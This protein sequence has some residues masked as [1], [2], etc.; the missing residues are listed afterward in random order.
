MSSRQFWF[1]VLLIVGTSIGAGFG[2]FARAR[3]WGPHSTSNTL[4]G[5]AREGR[6][7]INQPLPNVTLTDLEGRRNNLGDAKGKVIVFLVQGNKCPCSAAYVDRINAIHEEYGPKGVE[8]WAFNPNA[9]ETAEETRA[10]VDEKK[11][12]YSTAYDT[13][14]MV[15]GMLQAACTT[16]A[17]VADRDGVLRYHGRVDDNIY[18]P[19]KVTEH[20]LRVALD[21]VLAGEP[22][23]KPETS[24]YACTIS[25]SENL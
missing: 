15:A 13:N 5:P 20:D 21:A 9:N 14:G 11:V 10:F 23:P 4:L 1:V 8:I 17:W 7:T 18:E 3:W 6:V 19:D 2:L 16:E 12:R 22:V 25:R 24:A